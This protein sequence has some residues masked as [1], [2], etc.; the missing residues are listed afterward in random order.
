LRPVSP[1]LARCNILGYVASV[2][3]DVTLRVERSDAAR[4]YSLAR[5]R[6]LAGERIDMQQLAAELGVDRSTLFRWVGSRD[7]LVS[8]ILHE[9]GQKTLERVLR[10]ARAK[11]LSGAQLIAETL[12]GFA[13]ELITAPFFRTYLRR[14]PERAL[15]LLTTSASFIQPEMIRAVE[16]LLDEEVDPAGL[17]YPMPTR[18]LA[19]FV[20]RIGESFIYTDL[21]TGGIPDSGKART[22]LLA[23]L[24]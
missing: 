9:L 24:S 12:G 20:I 8:R 17:S 21:I 15:R 6:L 5:D 18:D 1:A 10:N 3:T 13:D 23:L 16:R 7:Q 19:Y 14:E 4:A 22:A 2:V 11:G